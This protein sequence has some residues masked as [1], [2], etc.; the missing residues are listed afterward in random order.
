M[1]HPKVTIIVL[2]WNGKDDTLECLKSL[3]DL[4]YPNYEVLVVDNGSSDD[5]VSAIHQAFPEITLIE[6]GENLGFAE[7]NSVGIRNASDADYILLLNNDTI[8]DSDFLGQLVQVAESNDKIGIV[9]PKIYYYEPKDMIWCAGILIENGRAFGIPIPNCS[10]MPIGCGEIDSGQYDEIKE[11]EAI[12]GCALM[13]KREVIEKIGLLNSDLFLI[14]EDVD[15]CLR[16]KRAGYSSVYA[17]GSKI[18]HKVSRSLNKSGLSSHTNPLTIYYWHRN[19]L[20]VVKH[21]F[22]K[23]N[24]VLI[25]FSYIC[26]LFPKLLFQLVKQS[27]LTLAVLSAYIYAIKDALLGRTPKRFIS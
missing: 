11:V 2:N 1:N 24:F 17:P 26:K 18:W 22:G 16:A 12:V 4:S 19:W 13:V 3:K 10:P 9:G 23:A 14:Q 27:Q 7:G 20:L 25:L 5:S 15:W 8:V 21:N 6:T